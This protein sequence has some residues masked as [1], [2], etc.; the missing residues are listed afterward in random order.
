VVAG[1]S[2]QVGRR[3]PDWVEAGD[4][5]LPAKFEWPALLYKLDRIDLS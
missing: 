4:P 2:V 3:D 1:L 5:L